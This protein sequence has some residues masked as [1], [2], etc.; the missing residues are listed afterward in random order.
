MGGLWK[1]DNNM[2]DKSHVLRSRYYE[3]HVQSAKNRFVDENVNITEQQ[4]MVDILHYNLSFDLFPEEKKFHASTTITGRILLNEIDTIQFNFYDNYIINSVKVNGNP[5][6]FVIKNKLISIINNYSITDTFEVKI[7]YTG[8]PERAGFSGF[9]FSKID[10]KSLVYTL[11][12]PTYAS[13]WFPC[14]DFPTDKAL[15]DIWITN[16]SSQVSVSNGILVDVENH[17]TRKTYHWKTLYPISTYL[18]ALYSS[19]YVHFN[20]EYI[21]IDGLDT[22]AIDYYVL[23]N[24]LE[25]A[26]IDFANHPKFIKFFAELFGEYPFVKEKY[27][28][29]EFLWQFGAMEH[30]T[31]TG[32]ASNI[33]GGKYF[34][35]DIYVHEV[36]HH[37]WGNAIGPKS[38]KDIW[39]NEGFSTYCEALFDEQIYGNDALQSKMIGLEKSDMRGSLSNPGAF[40][41]TQTVY[42]KGAWVLHML[43]WQLDDELFFEILRQYYEKYK[44]SNASTD[45]FRQ[46]C[47]NVSNRNLVKFFDQWIYG[48]GRI[49]ITY[50]WQIEKFGDSYF[51]FIEVNQEQEEYEEYHFP[52]EIA[53]Q[54]EKAPKYQTFYI[55]KKSVQFRIESKQSPEDIIIDPNNWL[56]ISADQK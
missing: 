35:E 37:W 36:A 56:L 40:L 41:F 53:I 4:K 8:S 14:N 10:G 3:N 12:E 42:N 20:D 6:E 43:R 45:D 50:D 55:D 32:V 19:D 33:L 30:Q 31:I 51:M 7:D 9:S 27:G 38:W 22:M 15:L 26:K 28:V 13:S 47:E 54:Y 39:L 21:S 25:N 11:S 23:A 2:S 24:K 29:A 44:Y 34:F 46:V 17:N 49:E 1:P 48:A 5:T 52:L 16:D 18:I